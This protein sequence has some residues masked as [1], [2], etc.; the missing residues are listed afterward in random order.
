MF[1]GIVNARSAHFLSEHYDSISKSQGPFRIL[2]NIIIFAV[3]QLW[4]PF[5]ARKVARR[6][7]KDGEW[8][9]STLKIC[10]S[11]FVDPNDIALFRIKHAEEMD[12]YMRRFEHIPIGRTIADAKTDH[13]SLLT[14]KLHFYNM[15]RSANIPHPHV[16]AYDKDNCLEIR[17][18]PQEGERLFVKPALGSGGRGAMELNVPFGVDT[19]NWLSELVQKLRKSVRGWNHDCWIIQQ[20]HLPH[21]LL[22]DLC[23]QVLPTARLITILNESGAPE[24]VSSVLRFPA[25]FNVIVDNIGLGG[26]SAP[27]DLQT[28]K[29]GPGCNGMGPG[30]FDFHPVSGAKIAHRFLPFWSDCCDIVTTLHSTHFEDH[31]MVGWDIG[32]AQEGPIVLEANARPSIILAQR[33]PRKPVGLTRMGQLIHFHLIKKTNQKP[34]R[35]R[36]LI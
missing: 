10:R 6:W 12:Y 8:I 30:E 25:S 27:I 18:L 29:L 14:D 2:L 1:P 24:I 26:L 17:R 4:L 15:C 22:K 20:R 23:G 32:I 16:I 7:G 21:P 19:E 28:G 3:F 35:R 13:S 9:A 34:T 11:R 5:R 36:L 31:T 33:A